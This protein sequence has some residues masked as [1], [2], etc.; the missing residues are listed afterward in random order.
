MIAFGPVPSRRLGKS[1]GIN[2]IPP[3]NCTYGCI[4]C[5]VGKTTN[6]TRVRQEFFKPEDVFGDVQELLIKVKKRG[7]KIDYFTFV[8]DGEPT[9]DINLGRAIDLLRLLDHK[10]AVITNGS[11]ITEQTV[12]DDLMKADYVT[13]KI[14]ALD[15]ETW[16]KTNRPHKDLDLEAIFESMIR[17][18][19]CYHGTLTTE[20]MLLDGINIMP[21]HIKRLAEF[22]SNLQPNQ[23]YVAIPTRP[24]VEKGVKIPDEA[25]INSV[26]QI[27]KEKI[28]PIEYL[29]GYEGNDVGYSGEIEKDIL[30]IAAVHPLKY[31]SIEKLLEKANANWGLVEK[32]LSQEKIK[33]VQYAG[34][35]FYLRC[36][37]DI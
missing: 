31:E 2:N 7:E 33:E 26:F 29:I 1:L 11:L 19:K 35:K 36:L 28:E 18:S 17:F 16:R 5:Q 30:N 32:L 10:I 27:F 14:D 34:S 6:M 22:I 24:T 20:T 23:A 8:P 21:S 3:K 12:Q 25:T 13:L 15:E 9:L 37:P 4:Y